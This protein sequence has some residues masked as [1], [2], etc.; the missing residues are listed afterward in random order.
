M[1]KFVIAAASGAMLLISSQ[2]MAANIEAGKKK[3]AEVCAACHG[4]D[5]N[6]PA[7]AFP[8]LAGQHAS[9]LMKSLNEYKSGVR[10]DPIMAGMAAALSK[11][12]I[13]DVSAYY[14][15]QS[16]LKTKY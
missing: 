6:S 9:Y 7:P 4:P 15:S 2:G 1:K 13:E 11:E 12:D 3:A 10:K 14:A 16:G 8:K 5:G